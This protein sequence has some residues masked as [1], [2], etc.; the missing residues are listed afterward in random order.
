MPWKLNCVLRVCVCT[1]AC[2]CVYIG[3]C[4]CVRMCVC[5]PQGDAFSCYTAGLYFLILKEPYIIQQC[6]LYPGDVQYALRLRPKSTLTLSFLPQRCCAV[7]ILP[8]HPPPPV[9]PLAPPHPSSPLLT[10]RSHL[11]KNSG[12]RSVLWCE[13]HR[14]GCNQVYDHVVKLKAVEFNIY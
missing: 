13:F 11:W 7:H 10:S 5:L 8:L 14:V 6:S 12:P 2:V 4:V 9:C 3:V 1:L